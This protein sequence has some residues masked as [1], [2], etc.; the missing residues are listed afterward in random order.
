M[1]II[2]EPRKIRTQIKKPE[3]NKLVPGE[4]KAR[5]CYGNF[6]RRFSAVEELDTNLRYIKNIK[7]RRHRA[8]IFVNCKSGNN[9]KTEPSYCTLVFQLFLN[10]IYLDSNATVRTLSY[11]QQSDSKISR[12]RRLRKFEQM[13]EKTG[14]ANDVEKQHDSKFQAAKRILGRPAV[15]AALLQKKLIIVNSL[16]DPKTNIT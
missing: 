1:K 9:L 14:V 6:R 2:N 8:D 12:Y 11:E 16:G 7:A 5:L 15:R 10:L 4:T 3:E 13:L